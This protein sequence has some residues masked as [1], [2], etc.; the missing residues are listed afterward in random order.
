MDRSQSFLAILA[1]ILLLSDRPR[2]CPPQRPEYLSWAEIDVEATDQPAKR[3]IALLA[4]DHLTGTD[5]LSPIAAGA[6]PAFRP[7]QQE[8]RSRVVR[9]KPCYI[10]ADRFWNVFIR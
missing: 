8:A 10:G 6:A 4:A 7:Q 3:A 1:V 9:G 5:D 2:K